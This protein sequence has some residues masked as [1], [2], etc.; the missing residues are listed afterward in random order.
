MFRG[1]EVDR[2]RRQKESCD[3][4]RALK[5]LQILSRDPA[6]CHPEC[7]KDR[8]KNN[9]RFKCI[10]EGSGVNSVSGTQKRVQHN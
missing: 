9:I 7:L 6:R 5:A 2:S 8:P 1:L 10:E 4:Q 3:V